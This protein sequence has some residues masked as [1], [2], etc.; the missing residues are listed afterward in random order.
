MD[1]STR[2]VAATLAAARKC[3]LALAEDV[4]DIARELKVSSICMDVDVH[5]GTIEVD[6]YTM[7]MERVLGFSADLGVDHD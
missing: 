1:E 6:M 2:D 5:T 3:L 4:A 7:K